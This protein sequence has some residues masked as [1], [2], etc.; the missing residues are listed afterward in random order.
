MWRNA[1]SEATKRVCD[2]ALRILC[3]WRMMWEEVE[4]NG[5]TFEEHLKNYREY[6]R[7]SNIVC[8]TEEVWGVPEGLFVM[9]DVY[10][11]DDGGSEQ[12]SVWA[13]YDPN[14]DEIWVDTMIHEFDTT[15]VVIFERDPTVNRRA[16]ND[17]IPENRRYFLNTPE[18]QGYTKKAT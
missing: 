8:E 7:P 13:E 6:S 3:D 2:E 12:I 17:T 15:R 14:T 11:G 9:F 5:T 10:D 18:D 1:K 4:P 16:I